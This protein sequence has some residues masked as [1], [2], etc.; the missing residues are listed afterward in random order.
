MTCSSCPDSV[1]P[2]AEPVP[3]PEPVKTPFETIGSLQLTNTGNAFIDLALVTPFAISSINAYITSLAVEQKSLKP[4]FFNAPFLFSFSNNLALGNYLESITTEGIY[5]YTTYFVPYEG[6]TKIETATVVT[7]LNI[8]TKILFFQI[9]NEFS[10]NSLELA[11]VATGQSDIGYHAKV[12]I[13]QS[14]IDKTISTLGKVIILEI[15]IQDPPTQTSD[16]V[17]FA[18]CNAGS[19]AKFYDCMQVS[20]ATECI[21][22]YEVANCGG[23]TLCQWDGDSCVRGCTDN[24]RNSCNPSSLRIYN[25]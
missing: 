8:E 3:V 10:Y 15:D 9:P 1:A 19:R 16:V 21:K 22:Y 25:S 23:R 20:K 11:A 7:I 14:F 24:S 13:P 2:S 4:T 5:I 17:P 12:Q 6:Y 18:D